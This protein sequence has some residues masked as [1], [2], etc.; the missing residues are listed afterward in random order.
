MMVGRALV[1]TIF[2]AEAQRHRVYLYLSLVTYSVAP[3]S[4]AFL[5]THTPAATPPAEKPLSRLARV[6]AAQPRRALRFDQNSRPFFSIP[7]MPFSPFTVWVTW[8][9]TASEQ[10]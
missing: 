9:S 4:K 1:I 5:P 7:W 2:V 3:W 8:K 6:T 10:N